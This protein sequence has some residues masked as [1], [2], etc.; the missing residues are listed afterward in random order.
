M[1]ILSWNVNGVRAVE[2]KGF[3]GWLKEEDPDILCVQETKAS[4]NQLSDALKFPVDKNGKPYFSYWSQAKRKGYSGTAIYTKEEPL[5]VSLMDDERFDA[6]G[7]VL[8]AEYP[9]FTVICAY[10]PNS[11]EGGARL[12]YKLDFCGAIFRH[13]ENL[14]KHKKNFILCGDYNIAHKPIDLARPKENEN[15]P[16]YF[17]QERSWMDA[18]TSGGFCDT[19][20]L[21]HPEETGKYSWWSYRGGARERNTGWRI[22]YHCVNEA[23]MPAVAASV[24][25]P[26][27]YGSD[28]CPVE[29]V[30][31]N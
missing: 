30:L 28:H 29:L 27:V 8:Q 20:R 17:P 18:W 21:L 23:F 3:L 4:P 7:R 11:Q 9:A 24:I 13:C 1:K 14:V 19:F 16:G 12:P 26:E 15:T 6:E 2:K 22:D 25:K 10:F 5:K 31:K